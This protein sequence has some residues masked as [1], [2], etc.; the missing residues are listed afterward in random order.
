MRRF[1]ITNT[2]KFT[3]QAE[4]VFNKYNVLIIIDC[5][6]A[7][8]DVETIKHFKAAAP[9][10]VDLLDTAFKAPTVIVEDYIDYIFADFYKD[11]PYKRNAFVAEKLWNKMTK[12]ERIIAYHNKPEYI[13]F[14]RRQQ[15]KND[16]QPMM[17]DTYLRKREFETEWNKIK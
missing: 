9:I 10:H 6:K 7:N 14:C 4:L 8:M 13:A 16:Y 1:I 2:D 5:S 17:A 15:A 3:G 12:T 11:W